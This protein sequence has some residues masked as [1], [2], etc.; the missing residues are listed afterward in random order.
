M[1]ETTKYCITCN[2]DGHTYLEC[3][4]VNFFDFVGAAFGLPSLT[5]GKTP[6]QIA[7]DWEHRND[8]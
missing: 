8:N 2:R 4:R 3:D 7:Y 6:E 5:S 1:T